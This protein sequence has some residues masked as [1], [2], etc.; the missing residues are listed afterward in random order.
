MSGLEIFGFK[1]DDKFIDYI[2]FMGNNMFTYA[3]II[4]EKDTYFIAHH[5]E[6]FEND[7]IDEGTLLNSPDPI[8]YLVEKCG[9]DVLKKIRAYSDSHFLAWCWRRYRE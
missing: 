9:N 4:D 6:F 3:F 8:D 1:T 7:K 5:Y 2:F